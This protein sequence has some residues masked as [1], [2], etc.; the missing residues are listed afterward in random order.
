MKFQTISS[1]I[2]SKES[3][4]QAHF[5]A[6]AGA[7][8]LEMQCNHGKNIIGDVPGLKLGLSH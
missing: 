1:T 7:I 6:S 5:E 8:G 2:C 3:D 4:T